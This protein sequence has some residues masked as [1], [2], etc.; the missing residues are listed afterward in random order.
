MAVP[1][2]GRAG[3]AE[4]QLL[5]QAR[6]GSAEAFCALIEPHQTR[7]L[8]QAVSLGHD[9]TAAEDLVQQTL[10]EAWRSL[11][12]FDGTCRFS[13]WLYAILLHRHQK[14][15]RAAAVRPLPMSRLPVEQARGGHD[16]FETITAAD[17]PPDIAARHADQVR[18][19]RQFVLGL[20]PV[21]RDVILLRYFEGATLAEIA[22][23]MGSS[24]GTVK[25][26]LHHALENLRRMNLT[27]FRGDTGI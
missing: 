3:F 7:L 25:S 27:E 11:K 20:S 1:T 13:T 4:D 19:L 8:R 24:I 15:L 2:P 6:D 17:Q 12:R 9:L 5:T 26:R 18:R 16:A 10:V 22:S 23:V 21:Q 14:V